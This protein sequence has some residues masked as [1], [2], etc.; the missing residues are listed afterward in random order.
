MTAQLP[1]PAELHEVALRR[2]PIEIHARAQEHTA[3]LLRELYLIAQQVRSSDAPELPARLVALVAELGNQFGALT[4]AQEQQLD[5]AVAAG[6]DEIDVV[7]RI[8]REAAAAS[9]HLGEILD[10]ADDFCRR[11]EHLL[12]LSA[13]ADLLLYRRWY[14]GE[15]VGQLAGEPATPW[16][17]YLARHSNNSGPGS[18]D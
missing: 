17:D 13:P 15:F 8:P 7:Y 12:T 6:V 14:L 11:G 4:T 16:P 18:N 2:V 1:P 10:E 5:A 9:Q 3:E